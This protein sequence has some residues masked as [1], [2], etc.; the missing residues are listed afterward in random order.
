MLPAAVMRKAQAELC[1]W[2]GRG[3]SIA[4]I[5][6]RSEDFA[7][8]AST[9][10]HTLRALYAVP[11][12]YHVLFLAGGASHQFAMVP[13]N[14]LGGKSHADYLHTGY[15]SAAALREAG[16]YCQP[17]EAVCCAPLQFTTI[18]P[19]NT[20][21]LREDSPYV[22]LAMNET[23]NG[24]EFPV[25]PDCG[26]IP[27]VADMTSTFLSRPLDISRFGLIFAGGQKNVC[28]AGL[29]VI[30]IRDTL[31][32]RAS[33]LCPE[34]Y[35][36]TAQVKAQSMLNTP[37]TFNWYMAGLNFAW[38]QQQGGLTAMAE[39]NRR[40]AQRLYDYIDTEDLYIND[41]DKPYR[42]C[43]NV[44]FSLRDPALDDYFVQQAEAAGLFALRGH[45]LRGGMRA[46]LYN[47]LPEA[48]V[49]ALVDFMQDFA[50]QHG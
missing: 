35:N 12:D 27:I 33:N 42:S 41:I 25:V 29:T 36:Y 38:L 17:R 37:P 19:H 43:M 2:R 14:L 13:L 32:G 5:S 24:L 7:A 3:T 31:L 49:I 45:R 48:A 16:R 6:H 30:I 9:T 4:E 20:W 50:R 39:I 26:E 47:A 11:D 44:S 40:K 28:P 22:Y 10:E 8:V 1:S 23:L 46:S 21:T 34:L 18:P 15:W